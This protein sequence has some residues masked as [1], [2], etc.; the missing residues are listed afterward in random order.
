MTA[1]DEIAQLDIEYVQNQA[2]I[3]ALPVVELNEQGRTVGINAARAA[4]TA[5]QDWI[6]KRK[7]QLRCWTAEVYSGG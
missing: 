7:I 4:L 6:V 5:R 2:A 1:D 3:L